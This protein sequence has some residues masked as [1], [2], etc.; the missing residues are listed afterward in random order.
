MI[1]ELALDLKG[2]RLRRGEFV[3][4]PLDLELQLGRVVGLVG[5]NG[6]GKTTTL[7]CLA[8]SLYPEAGEV[9]ILGCLASDA[10]GSWKSR[11]GYV[12][13]QLHHFPLAD[14]KRH[15]A[16]LSHF[17]ADWSDAVA[18]ELVHRFRLDP[19]VPIRRLSPGNRTK[20]ALVAALAHQ[21]R[22]LLLD[23]PT[24]G[25]DPV[26]RAELF[27]VLFEHMESQ[28]MTVLYATHIVDD[29]HRFADELVFLSNGRLHQHVDKDTLLQSWCRLR[30]SWSGE[31]PHL[32]GSTRR[33]RY[34]ETVELVSCDR[35][36]TLG[37]LESLGVG[38]VQQ[39]EMDLEA[40][41][42]SILKEL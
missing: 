11:T 29:L 13:D 36:A 32:P 21:P 20:V 31:L 8:G 4:G 23:E 6:S 14:A 22:F 9:R 24:A 33:S 1:M 10:D 5:P 15:F 28:S 12:P 30:F 39:D 18:R 2:L 16:L 40:I 25:L 34:G 35:D 42:V 41:T 7:R 17:Y 27:E 26:V 3:L 37:A 19:G 38:R